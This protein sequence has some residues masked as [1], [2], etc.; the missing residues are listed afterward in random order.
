MV[1]SARVAT[2]DAARS[3]RRRAWTLPRFS[4]TLPPDLRDCHY[5]AV[6]ERRDQT[7]NRRV[8]V[9]RQVR[10]GPFAIV[11]DVKNQTVGGESGREVLYPLHAGAGWQAYDLVVRAAEPLA[12]VPAIREAIWR[13]DRNQAVGTPIELQHLVD[14]TL[15][16]YRLLS[17]LLCGF[18]AIALKLVALGVC[19]V[20]GY[21]V[22][23]RTK[24]MAIRVALGAPRW[25]VTATVLRDCPGVRQPRPRRRHPARSRCG[26]GPSRLLGRR[27]TA[28]HGD[29]GRR[30]R[31][32]AD[33]GARRGVL[34]G[35]RRAPR[36]DPIAALR[37][38]QPSGSD[39]CG[40]VA[41][42]RVRLTTDR[43]DRAPF[44]GP[45]NLCNGPV[46]PV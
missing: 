10:A 36:P 22:A 44:D 5:S 7:R 25:R 8:F 27:G 23:Q 31:R 30:R 24:E 35:A 46:K 29:A 2:K 34:L 16:P 43:S 11:A 14:R 28:R 15:K 12:M 42:G 9:E 4:S 39:E 38:E 13:V 45:A 32:R 1:F 26:R 21:R 3:W 20:V 19:G 18:A 40:A 33:R 6:G 17:W 41:Y 37:A